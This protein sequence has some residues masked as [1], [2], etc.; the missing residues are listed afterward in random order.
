MS[1][2]KNIGVYIP[3]MDGKD[4]FLA[5]KIKQDS[6]TLKTKDG[7]PNF[8]RYRNVFDYSLDLI[9]LRKIARS[10]Y[11]GK[12]EKF[13]FNEN[14]KE[15]CPKI[16]NM[17]FKYAIKEFNK[18][19]TSKNKEKHEVYVAYGYK[20]DDLEF[21]DCVARNKY[22]E[23]VGVICGKE[24]IRPIE[25]KGFK[26]NAKKNK[27]DGVLLTYE[28]K[29]SKTIKNSKQIREELYRNGF[30]CDGVKYVRFKRS[31]GSAR[32]GKCLFIAEELYEDIFNYSKCG[33]NVKD[34]QE[35]DL[36]SFEA[37][38]SLTTSSI[39]DT[40]KI[41][42]KNF[43]IIDDFNSNF[44]ENAI[45]TK[46]ADD[47][48][49]LETYQDDADI[50]N[51]IWDGQGFIDKSLMGKYEDKGM[52]LLRN[53]F[54]KCCAFNT[55]IQQFFKDNNITD[56]SQLNGFTIADDISDIKFITTPSSI[57]YVKFDKDYKKWMENI[58]DMFGIV[59]YDKDTHYFD[60]ELVQTHYQLINTLQFTKE[61]M[62][63]FLQPSIDYISAINMDK[64]IMRNHIKW[65]DRDDEEPYD[66]S[67][68]NDIV[69]TMLG[70]DNGF[71]STKIYHDFK[72]D[73][74]DSFIN[75]IKKGHVYI[76][77]TYAVLLG[78]PYEMLLQSIG[79]F[80]GEGYMD[81]G[82]IHNIRYKNGEDILGCRSPHVT[83]SNILLAKNKHYDLISKYFNLTNNIVCVNAIGEN[84]LERLSSADYD[85]DSM[86]ITNEKLLI[87]LA[88]I[89]YDVF[90]VP[91]SMVE[92]VKTKRYYTKEQLADLDVKTSKNKI[93]EI[94]NCSQIL[95]SLLW[96]MLYE[97]KNI[98]DIRG[99]A[100]DNYDKI[101]ELFFDICQ[102]DVMSCIEIDKA[103]KEF[104]INN[105]K[106][107]DKIRDKYSDF[108]KDEDGKKIK[109][110]F[111]EFLNKSKGYYKKGAGEYI[112]HETSMDYLSSIMNDKSRCD[113]KQKEDYILFSNVFI[114]INY[115]SN[116]ANWKQIKSIRDMSYN[117]IK[118]R[119]AIWS[120]DD[121]ELT[122]KLLM[123]DRIKE[124]LLYF[125]S[126]ISINET[127]IYELI[128]TIDMDKYSEIK[129]T[130]M[131]VLFCS[132]NKSLELLLNYLKKDKEIRQYSHFGVEFSA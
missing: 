68:K 56:I 117:Y 96:D 13:T 121:Y 89:N 129:T 37:Y 74:R 67:T 106:E 86:I 33:I 26:T 103:K 50:S 4:I 20:Y 29:S 12:E 75:N 73:I 22:D 80:D 28:F 3:S 65:K 109:P 35:I 97:L 49:S 63:S 107:L 92:A 87:D 94:I 115:D 58:S 118:K 84:T 110:K 101:K 44:K 100:K 31:S 76:N 32:V 82:T 114:P 9:E 46:I 57:K 83:I 88:R 91:T 62:Q 122:E 99:S 42:P 108:L 7:K 70:Y 126:N 128:K 27:G 30:V 72:K 98:G 25:I 127:T 130:M 52:I 71:E 123:N 19:K 5:N 102:L 39:I 53:K 6:F 64:H 60:G 40:I 54:F 34:G 105:T 16:I 116:S 36:A 132:Y 124:E 77:G 41:E 66:M 51:S 48:V 59:K 78:N 112:H 125:I 69:Y 120:N 23:V 11:W 113:R 15:Y 55:N 38:I 8:R 18:F 2:N 24:V 79:K 119:K 47:N 81:I 93:G 43:L 61:E 1:K 45:I 131:M 104:I 85:S 14:G 90:K 95:N 21:N 10:K 111:F 17:T